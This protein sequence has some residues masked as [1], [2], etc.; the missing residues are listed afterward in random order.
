MWAETFPSD[1]TVVQE[2]AALLTAQPNVRARCVDYFHHDHLTVRL[3]GIAQ[4]MDWC[5]A[6]SRGRR[7]SLKPV[8][9]YTTR[10]TWAEAIWRR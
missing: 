9:F 10:V 2:V 4:R 5:S 6:T 1:P 7:A 8:R 3:F